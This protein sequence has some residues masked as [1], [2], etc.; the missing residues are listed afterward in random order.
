MSNTVHGP[1][2]N[3][4]KS[5]IPSPAKAIPVRANASPV[6]ALAMLVRRIARA[7]LS[8]AIS[9]LSFAR[10]LRRWTGERLLQLLRTSSAPSTGSVLEKTGCGSVTETFRTEKP[11]GASPSG[12]LT[13]CDAFLREVRYHR[14]PSETEAIPTARR[15]RQGMIRYPV[16]KILNSVIAAVMK[17]MPVR[18]KARP[19]LPLD[20]AV[21]CSESSVLWPAR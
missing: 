1:E 3:F 9:V 7:V 8:S 12:G 21:L 6:R 13:F 11:G 18:R 20:N 4:Q 10:N 16:P 17:A 5:P 15:R 19:V 14:R 2:G